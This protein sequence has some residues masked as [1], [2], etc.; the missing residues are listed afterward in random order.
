MSQRKNTEQQ[1]PSVNPILVKLYL[2]KRPFDICTLWNILLW[3]VEFLDV[4]LNLYFVNDSL[5]S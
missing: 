5:L 3:F 4:R 2:E 1:Q